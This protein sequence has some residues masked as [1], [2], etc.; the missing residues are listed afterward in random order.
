MSTIRNFVQL[1]GN[2][3]GTPEITDFESGKKVA[4]FSLDGIKLR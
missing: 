3:G 1:I 2:A 4:R